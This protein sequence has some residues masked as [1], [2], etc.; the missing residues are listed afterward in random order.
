MARVISYYK[1]GNYFVKLLCDGTKI[2]ET[3]DDS[4]VAEFPDSIDL[5]ITN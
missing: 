3:S 5:K 2:K 4:F 1:N